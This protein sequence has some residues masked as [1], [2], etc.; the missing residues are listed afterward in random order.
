VELRG[1]SE[2]WRDFSKNFRIIFVLKIPW[3]GIGDWSMEDL[4]ATCP[5]YSPESY[6]LGA[7]L[8]ETSPQLHDEGEWA[9]GLLVGGENERWR[10]W[11]GLA[12]MNDD[13][14]A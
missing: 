5:C 8:V 11:F 10:G 9:K 12:A 2:K 7:P 6:A 4:V 13:G 3:T 1:F 14:N